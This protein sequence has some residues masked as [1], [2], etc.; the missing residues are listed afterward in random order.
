MLLVKN[1][2]QRAYKRWGTAVYRDNPKIGHP[3]WELVVVDKDGKYEK[4]T[5]EHLQYAH[6]ISDILQALKS[7]G[8]K[9]ITIKS[10]F[11][12]KL[13][14]NAERITFICKK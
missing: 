7:A 1:E 8:F 14:E 4:L 10:G 2:E 13:T 9:K 5:E 11:G 3:Q 12:K 6:K